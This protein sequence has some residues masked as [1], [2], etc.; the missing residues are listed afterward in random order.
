MTRRFK[1]IVLSTLCILCGCLVCGCNPRNENINNN[2]SDGEGKM[3]SEIR[4][5]IVS[6]EED[7]DTQIEYA[8]NFESGKR[9][10]STVTKTMV[11]EED[12]YSKLQE[13]EQFI[14]QKVV[15]SKFEEKNKNSGL[16]D[17]KVIWSV[18]VS[19]KNSE[20]SFVQQGFY[21]YPKYWKEL[22]DIVQK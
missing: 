12:D 13:L 8:I 15:N 3:S 20:E 10:K 18:K 9:T 14:Q 19:Y 2:I 21:E 5:I 1:R 4:K 17:S 11:E 7:T 16:D 6:Y 22:I